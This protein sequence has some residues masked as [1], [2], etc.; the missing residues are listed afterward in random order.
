MG[1]S[2]IVEFKM[3][4]K[5]FGEIRLAKREL[6]KANFVNEIESVGKVSQGEKSLHEIS[7]FQLLLFFSFFFSSFSIFFYFFSFLLRLNTSRK[8][9]S[10]VGKNAAILC[11]SSV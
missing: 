2:S 5:Q 8:D 1:Y 6:I 4:L 3:V 7:A 11:C 9:L 10:E